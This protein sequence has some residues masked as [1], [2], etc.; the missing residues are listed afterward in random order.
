MN[1]LILFLIVVFSIP[2][3]ANAASLIGRLGMGTTNQIASGMSALSFKLQQN[4]ASAIGGHFGI[5]SSSSGMNY[6][7]GLKSYR[8]IYEE[9]QLHF[10]SA[11]AAGI[12]SYQNSA[13]ATESGY[14]ID[15]TFG[16]EFSFQGI[17]SVGFSFEFGVGFNK[18]NGET[19]LQTLGYNMIASSV[20]FYL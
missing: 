6:A 8:Y 4:R 5:D 14:Q 3:Q 9:P 15:A 16:S 10:F 18:Y 2:H 11:I 7:L 17:E 19:H 20:H 13:D 12:F 1:N